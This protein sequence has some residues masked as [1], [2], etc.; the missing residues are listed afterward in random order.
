LE[1]EQ[2]LAGF[3]PNGVGNTL[4]NIFGLPFSL[5]QAGLVFIPVPWDVTVSNHE[6][7]CHAP[8][9]IREQSAQIDLFD[10]FSPDAWKKGMAMEPIDAELVAVNAV[11]RQKAAQYIGYMEKGG[12]PEAS[13]LMQE[14]AGQVNQVCG[15]MVDRIGEK[16]L[17]YANMGQKTFVV[18]GDHSVSLGNIRAMARRYPGFGILQI[19]AHADLR[20]KYQGFIHSHASVMRNAMDLEGLRKVVQVGVREYCHEEADFMKDQAARLST[21]FDRDIH[22]ELYRGKT[23]GTICGQIVDELPEMVYVSFDADGLDPAFFPNTGTPVPGGITYN[24]AM[25]LL[26]MIINS[27]RKII[28]ADLVETG[29]SAFDAMMACRIIYRL[30][31]MM[32]HS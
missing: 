21:W 8:R 16:C 30:A 7:T 32:L 31:G 15:M 28:G 11:H 14:I 6:G 9:M 22:Q 24:Q 18:G 29:P 25:Y 19:D 3:D 23:W 2:L 13:L 20:N 26:E 17:H 5:E 4:G 1:N 12:K 10:P 27:N